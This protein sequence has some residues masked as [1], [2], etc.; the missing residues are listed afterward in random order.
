MQ[1][2]STYNVVLGQIWMLKIMS[3]VHYQQ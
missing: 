3:L 1:E 2:M